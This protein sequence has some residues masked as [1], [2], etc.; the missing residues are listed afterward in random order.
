MLG[1]QWVG[2]VRQT[3]VLDD[4]G[5]KV[6]DDAHDV[7]TTESVVWKR[8]ALIEPQES[9]IPGRAEIVTETTTTTKEIVWVFLPVD[10]DTRAITSAMRL[11]DGGAATDPVTAGIGADFEMRGNAIVEVSKRGREDHVFCLAE[12]QGG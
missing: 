8:R 10:A 12:R 1:S 6:R 2:I 7:R 11:R 3:P 9:A 5:N 4:D